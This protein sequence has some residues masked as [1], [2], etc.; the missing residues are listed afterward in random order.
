MLYFKKLAPSDYDKVTTI[1]NKFEP[2]SDFNF[3]SLYSWSNN[4]KTM[5]CIDDSSLYIIMPDYLTGNPIYSFLSNSPDAI[6][7]FLNWRRHIKEMPNYLFNLLPEPS[8][9]ASREFLNLYNKKSV[10]YPEEANY[11]YILKTKDFY[12]LTGSSYEDI[13]YKINKFSREWGGNLKVIN[14]NDNNAAN[15]YLQKLITILNQTKEESLEYQALKQFLKI[16]NDLKIKIYYKFYTLNGTIV[17]FSSYEIINEKYAMGHFLKTDRKVK[18]LFYKA[19]YDV[20]GELCALNIPFINIEQDLGIE[21]LRATKNH[22]R[23]FKLLKKYTLN[24]AS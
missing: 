19:V 8:I 5:I 4:N 17:G 13:R 20:C 3:L 2:F 15:K 18:N 1:V 11:D 14:T 12:S 16:S 9:K 23:P 7:K 21:T 24:I 10:I 22:L 6:E